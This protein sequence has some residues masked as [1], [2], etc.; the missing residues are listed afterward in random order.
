[1]AT[2][3]LIWCCHSFIEYQNTKDENEMY[4]E[5]LKVLTKGKQYLY[6]YIAFFVLNTSHSTPSFMVTDC[7]IL[8]DVLSN[9]QIHFLTPYPISLIVMTMTI[10]LKLAVLQFVQQ[11]GYLNCYFEEN[12]CPL[13]SYC[14]AQASCI[15][16]PCS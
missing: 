1:M 2:Q 3:S 8:G 7:Y 14:I 15:S 11:F 13:K 6:K 12:L 5:Q 10:T 4:Q 9:N 16:Y